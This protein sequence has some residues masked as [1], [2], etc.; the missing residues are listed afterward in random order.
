[1]IILRVFL[2]LFLLFLIHIVKSQVG[3]GTITP[4]PAAALDINSTSK[5]LLLPR[6][7]K[8]ER[9]NISNPI[10]GLVIWCTN[11][12]DFGQMQ[13]FNSSGWTDMIGGV[14]VGLSI[15]DFYGGGKVAYILQTGDPGFISGEVHGF[16]AAPADQSTGAPWGC[17]E[18]FIGGTSTSLGTG[19]SNT[20]AIVSGCSTSGIAARICD[21]L[22]LNGYNDW[23]LPS[24]DELNKLYLNKTAIGG[25]AAGEYWTSSESTNMNASVQSFIN[26]IQSFNFKGYPSYVRAVR[27]F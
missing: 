23:Y 11:C 17:L 19:Q 5:G 25:F 2:S 16:I 1:M 21:E 13:V 26:G 18:I 20:I 27:S 22:S 14:P 7:T 15:G 12:G 9:N 3:I 8:S 6:M 10:A 24:K 4:N